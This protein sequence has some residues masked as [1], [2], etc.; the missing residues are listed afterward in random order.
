MFKKREV[1][2]RK[3]LITFNLKM[4]HERLIQAYKQVSKNK[5][6]NTKN[7]DLKTLDSYWNTK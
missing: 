1:V 3:G 4:G 5:A 7:V 6:S 2:Q